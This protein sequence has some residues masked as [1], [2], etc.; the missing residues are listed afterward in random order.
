[1]RRFIAIMLGMVLFCGCNFITAI[2]D[3]APKPDDDQVQPEPEPDHEYTEKQHWEA[4]ARYISKG[5]FVN[6]D[7][8]VWV[9]EQLKTAGYINDISRIEDMRKKCESID[10]SNRDFIANKLI[11]GG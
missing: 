5:V 9:V 4:V 8:V 7:E 10:E 2:P 3:A 6:T 1:M 11:G